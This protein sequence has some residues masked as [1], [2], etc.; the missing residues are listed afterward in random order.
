VESTRED[1]LAEDT[2][3]SNARTF[4]EAVQI[5]DSDWDSGSI[6]NTVSRS[7]V[8]SNVI[9]HTVTGNRETVKGDIGRKQGGKFVA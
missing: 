9:R 5:S 4:E 2:K 6:S 1:E 3:R 8:E 7:F